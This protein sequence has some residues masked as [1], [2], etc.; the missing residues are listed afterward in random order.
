[1]KFVFCTEPVYQYY[2][3][4]IYD[5]DKDELDKQLLIQYGDYR[6]KYDL[7]QQQSEISSN[8]FK[9]ELTSIDYPRNQWNYVG[10]LINKLTYSYLIDNIEFENIFSDI[11]FNHSEMEFYQFY[12]AIYKFYNGAEIFI[13]VGNDSY[14]DMVTQMVCNVLSKTYGIH[15]QIIYDIDDVLNIRDD[16]DFSPKGNQI[17]YIQRNLYIKL[18]SKA[19]IESLQIWHPFDMNSYKDALE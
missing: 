11:L 3:A 17:A 18:S 13:I 16:I 9:A 1:M 7:M 4:N 5:N 6:D 2:R 10:Q 15:P 12:T 8:I 14:S 19:Q